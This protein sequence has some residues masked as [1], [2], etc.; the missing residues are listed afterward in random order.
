M[1]FVEPSKCFNVKEIRTPRTLLE[2][3][4]FYVPEAMEEWDG[5][6][7]N[8][9]ATGNNLDDTAVII[10][11]LKNKDGKYQEIRMNF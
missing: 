9:I 4:N 5:Y 2:W 10:V 1:G 7:F 6:D 11:Y 3:L 8:V